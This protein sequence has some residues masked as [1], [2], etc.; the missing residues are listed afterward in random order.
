MSEF[1]DIP[2]EQDT[3][4]IFNSPM[5]WGELSIV[6]EKWRWDGITAESIIFLTKDVKGL[7]DKALEADVRNGPLVKKTSK[8]T[9][10][11]GKK[12]TFVNFNFRG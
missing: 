2:R 7:N 11:R 9:I 10:K 8:V 12:Y 5:R 6:Y 1:I 3:R 4:I